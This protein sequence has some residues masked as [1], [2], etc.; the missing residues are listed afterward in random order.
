[1]SGADA[2]TRAQI[3][4]TAPG[5]SVWVAANAGSGKT[6]V[7]AKRVAR[8]L[9]GRCPPE[10]ILCLT[11]T[12]AAAAEMQTRLVG[13]LGG[14]ALAPDD[15]LRAELEALGEAGPFGAA[16]LAE[17]RR[18]FAA[19]LETP[20]GLKIQ[21][22]HAFCAALLR[23][24]PL[25]A[26]A[27]P[28]F[29]EL[30][31]RA[32]AQIRAALRDAM[33]L[34]A[35]AG[36]DAAFD[37]LAARVTDGGLDALTR[38]IGGLPEA[39]AADPG[40]VLTAPGDAEFAA[41]LPEARA[42]RALAAALRAGGKTDVEAAGELEAAAAALTAG[43]AE[44]AAAGIEAV[45]L[46][47]AGVRRSTAKFPSKAAKA[48]DPGC[49]AATEALL[50]RAEALREARLRRAALAASEDLHA[51]ARPLLAGLEREAARRGALS[52]DELV[53]R[54]AAL[55]DVEGMPSFALYRT[56]GGLDHILVDEAQDTS[57]RQWRI[58]RALADEFLAGGA[59]AKA[60]G[61]RTLFAVGDEKQSIYSFQ[62]A[63]PEAFGAMRDHFGAASG[64]A[65]EARTLEWSFRSAPAV[66]RAVDAVFAEDATGLSADGTPPAHRAF[67][68]AAPGRVELWPLFGKAEAGAAPEWWEPVDMPA[69]TA[70]DARLAEA[71][72]DRVAGL[73]QEGAPMPRRGEAARPMRP[74]DVLFLLRSRGR[75]AGGLVAALKAR[76][77]PVAG[78]DRLSLSDSLAA[79]DLLALLRVALDPGDDLAL[80]E[81]LRSPLGGIS[82]EALFELAHGRRGPLLGRVRARWEADAAP[83]ALVEDVLRRADFDRPFE[84]MQRAL[85]RHGGRAAL[86]A[87][88]APE[89][90]DA[91][92]ELLAQALAYERAEVPTLPG[93]LAWME[94]GEGSIKR[95]MEQGGDAVR[96]MTVHGAK[97]LE[98]PFVILADAGPARIHSPSPVQVVGGVALWAG[99]GRAQD[100]PEPLRGA[101]EAA[102]RREAEE[103]RRLL[104][105]AMTRA[106]SRLLVAGCGDETKPAYDGCWHHAVA[107]GLRRA[108]AEEAECPCG[109]APGKLD[110]GDLAAPMLR[111]DDGWPE[112]AET[113]AGAPSEAPASHPLPDPARRPP[114]GPEPTKRIAA[115]A[116]EADRRPPEA[117]EAPPD[118]AP[119]VPL[120]R[121]AARA[122]G[123]AIHHALDRLAEGA[124]RGPLLA[125]MA[126]VAPGLPAAALEAGLLEAE[127]ALAPPGLADWLGPPEETLV[128]ATLSAEIAPGRRLSGRVDRVW[129]PADPAAPIRLLDWKTGAAP[130][131]APEGYL[132]Q[133]AAYRAAIGLIHPGRR[134]EAALVWTAVPRLEAAPEA[135]LD[136]A[137]ARLLAAS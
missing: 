2:A 65:V 107:E 23:R 134:I 15:A 66:L 46:T 122:R 103:R 47:R 73:I 71:L 20:G 89:E 85:V 106:E 44:V 101:M 56:D 1:M 37:R 69:A 121:A 72:A 127:R 5:A 77:V 80:A 59:G 90:A 102:K 57:P 19:A 128:E 53:R 58:V 79:G 83:R 81:V 11:Y 48:A 12:R 31:D 119:A 45:G 21:T 14:W 86:T 126:A 40:T 125:E 50:D 67:H 34:A 54:A 75:I 55:L 113:G 137:L 39:F 120:G 13:L 8:L 51:F 78:A 25:E 70:P 109:L 26:G 22:L 135:A 104:Y 111:L 63:A 88:L 27:P 64:G 18:L 60:G 76:G 38:R 98:A 52:F 129:I 110:P 6:S 28:D 99:T 96:V 3:A 84:L 108:G 4:A 17:A 95:E 97:G 36:E 24:F 118:E 62:G 35:E 105:V 117:T 136:A 43:D 29:R 10:R 74:G 94:A 93:F 9:L 32:E 112:R 33:A 124:A 100:C 131:R 92:D 116:F 61:P 123:D 132:R 115:S 42:L 130:E 91:I 41:M 133:L 82:E 16:R 114:A 30:D 49:E 68:A 7:L 87:R